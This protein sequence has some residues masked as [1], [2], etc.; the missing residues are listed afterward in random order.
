[1]RVA[2]R[3]AVQLCKKFE[4]F[5]AAPYYCPAGL[6][7][8]AFGSTF[9]EDGRSV[10]MSDPPVTQEYGERLLAH[11]LQT[12]C[13]PA[14]VKYTPALV[15]SEEALGAL[16]DFIYNLGAGRYKN[17]TLRLRLN[18]KDWDEAQLEIRRWVRASGRVLRGLQLRRE[19]EAAYLPQ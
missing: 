5:S 9:Y 4:G 10:S 12:Q 6:A 11:V 7:T 18:Q 15:A 19:A 3:T 2:L 17:S 8:V 14:A 16:A 13:L 1:M